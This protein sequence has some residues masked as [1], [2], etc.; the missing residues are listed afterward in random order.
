M[1]QDTKER[2]AAMIKADEG[3]AKLNPDGTLAAYRDSRGVW[4]IGYGCNLI[5]RGLTPALAE[6]AR[7]TMQQAEDAFD[8]DFDRCLAGLDHN[9]P[10]WPSLAPARQAVAVSAMYVLGVAKVLEFAPTIKLITDHDYEGAARH[11]EACAWA[12]QA[13][14][15]VE[16]L[17]AMMRAGTWPETSTATPNTTE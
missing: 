1:D 16:R 10:G 4:T 8:V 17:A 13:L 11:M 9:F 6:A 14:Q 5:A 15:R 7:W 2:T 12:R 3:C